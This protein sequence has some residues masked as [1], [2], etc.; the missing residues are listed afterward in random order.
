M[1]SLAWLYIVCV[2]S[3]WQPKQIHHALSNV[4]MTCTNNST[5]TIFHSYSPFGTQSSNDYDL[6][7]ITST[8]DDSFSQRSSAIV[9]SRTNEITYFTLNSQG[10]DKSTLF[11]QSVRQFSGESSDQIGWTQ[12]AHNPGFITFISSQFTSY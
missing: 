9:I 3:G 11:G 6:I 1:V 8:S 4:H 2:T 12:L 10:L 7:T 5:Q